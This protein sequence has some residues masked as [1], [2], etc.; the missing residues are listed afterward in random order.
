[1]LGSPSQL[2]VEPELEIVFSV[3]SNPDCHDRM[4]RA[5]VDGVR[6]KDPQKTFQS[7][8][9]QFNTTLL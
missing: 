3:F 5:S 8:E 4:T 2:V 9:L 6:G 7:Q 1:M